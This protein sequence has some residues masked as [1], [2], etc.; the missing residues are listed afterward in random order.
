M[1]AEMLDL[2]HKSP[3]LRNG[4]GVGLIVQGP[5]GVVLLKYL[6]GGWKM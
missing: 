6:E 1:V 5:R 2:A 3:C 4:A